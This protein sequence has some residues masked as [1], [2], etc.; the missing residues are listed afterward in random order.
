MSEVRRNR[1]P[2]QKE[3]AE[4][5]RTMSFN[6]D[7]AVQ[8]HRPDY[9]NTAFTGPNIGFDKQALVVQPDGSKIEATYR[10]HFQ[11]ESTLKGWSLVEYADGTYKW[12]ASTLLEHAASE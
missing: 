6:A 9:D 4:A 8:D 10:R 5:W 1:A 3:Y 7:E 11:D 12:V 2:E